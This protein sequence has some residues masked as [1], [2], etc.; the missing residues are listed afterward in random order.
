MKRL[1]KAREAR[2]WTDGG[3]LL[4]IVASDA[5]QEAKKSGGE[6]LSVNELHDTSPTKA[7]PHPRPHLEELG[8][9]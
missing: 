4:R 3:F 5:M 7:R 2:L 6:L 9:Y 8:T 1:N